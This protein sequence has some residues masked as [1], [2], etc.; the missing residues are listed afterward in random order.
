MQNSAWIA[1]ALRYGDKDR[2]SEVAFSERGLL[3]DEVTSWLSLSLCLIFSNAGQG[4]G[5][6]QAAGHQHKME[7]V[8]DLPGERSFVTKEWEKLQSLKVRKVLLWE[9]GKI[10]F[11]ILLVILDVEQEFEEISAWH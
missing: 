6:A 2:Q 1:E 8:N 7:T 11:F 3:S 4:E 10:L 5:V 9:G